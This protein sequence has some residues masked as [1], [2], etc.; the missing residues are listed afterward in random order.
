MA[1][2]QNQN[3]T[4]EIDSNNPNKNNN[5]IIIITSAATIPRGFDSGAEVWSKVIRRQDGLISKGQLEQ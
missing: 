2:Q 1:A 5:N 3:S 4:K